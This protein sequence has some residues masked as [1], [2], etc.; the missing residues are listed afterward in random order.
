[1]QIYSYPPIMECSSIQ[2][3]EQSPYYPLRSLNSTTIQEQ[4]MY[5]GYNVRPVSFRPS[6]VENLNP[7]LPHHHSPGQIVSSYQ[8]P[9]TSTHPYT[10]SSPAIEPPGGSYHSPPGFVRSG[11]H[12][13]TSVPRSVESAMDQKFEE[14]MGSVPLVITSEDTERKF[15]VTEF[16][17]SE[18][19]EDLVLSL[20]EANMWHLFDAS[21]NEMIV[22]K[23]GR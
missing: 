4:A 20:H 6:S 3:S 5:P 19:D 9:Y 13:G 11:G 1:M 2:T 14:M 10:S 18:L 12:P 23:M 15:L 7:T 8:T 16:M 21:N 17:S 22:T